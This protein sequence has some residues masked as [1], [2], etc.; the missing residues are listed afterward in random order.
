MPRRL[1]YREIFIK[2]RDRFTGAL[3]LVYEYTNVDT[4]IANTCTKAETNIHFSC[5]Y[6]K[7]ESI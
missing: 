7:T 1:H 6:D 5:W 2:L 4:F 3:K